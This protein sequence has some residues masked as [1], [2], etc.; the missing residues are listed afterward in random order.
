MLDWKPPYDPARA[1]RLRDLLHDCVASAASDQDARLIE[2]SWLLAAVSDQARLRAMIACGAYESAAALVIGE[3][4]PYLVSRGANGVCLASAPF[5]D[6]CEDATAQAATPALA[7]L[8]AHAA[9]LL[10]QES[11]APA[12]LWRC[13]PPLNAR[14]H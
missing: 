8:S 12:P 7:M 9:A 1:A 4:R 6:G 10:A 13:L 14:L 11:R 2:A 3:G 5:A